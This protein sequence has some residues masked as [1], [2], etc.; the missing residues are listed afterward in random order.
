MIRNL[1][2]VLRTVESPWINWGWTWLHLFW[3]IIQAAVWRMDWML[4]GQSWCYHSIFITTK[5]EKRKNMCCP[6]SSVPAYCLPLD[7]RLQT[8]SLEAWDSDPQY[9]QKG[10]SDSIWFHPAIDRWLLKFL[11][12]QVLAW[13]KRRPLANTYSSHIIQHNYV[14]EGKT[15]GN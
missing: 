13:S 3:N 12:A 9:L 1:N 8:L 14:V 15:L 5:N 2:F 10:F 6:V 11:S 7:S 4:Q